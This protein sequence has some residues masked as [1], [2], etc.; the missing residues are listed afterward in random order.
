MSD[1]TEQAEFWNGR[2]GDAWAKAE[3]R[4]DQ[5]MTPLSEVALKHIAAQP[6]ERILDVGCGCGSM[7]IALSEAGAEVFGVDISQ[8]MIDQAN[9]NAQSHSAVSFAVGDAAAMAFDSHFNAVFS[10]YGVMFFAD[11]VGA[12]SNIRS[13]LADNGRMVFLCWQAPA[14]NPWVSIPAAA[15]K[16]FS[17]DEPAPDPRAPGPFAF[18]DQDYLRETLEAAGFNN[19]E[20]SSL[21]K[22]LHLGASVEEA[23]QFQSQIGPLSGLLAELDEET[24]R[25]ATEAVIEALKPHQSSDGLKLGAATWLVSASK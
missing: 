1:N 14:E 20:I 15:L 25:K 7:S 13:A 3:A 24:G 9:I 17:A 11:P 16:P 2:M 6:G 8:K 21:K 18:A 19:V 5:L 22:T 12:F 23:M 10:R 4:I